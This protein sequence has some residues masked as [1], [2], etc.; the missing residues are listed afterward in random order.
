MCGA[1]RPLGDLQVS[2]PETTIAPNSESNRVTR[3]I[4]RTFIHA[5]LEIR[6]SRQ[7]ELLVVSGRSGRPQGCDPLGREGYV[8]R[9]LR[10]PVLRSTTH[11]VSLPP[12]PGNDA[13]TTL[14]SC[15][16]RGTATVDGP[17]PTGVKGHVVVRNGL[18]ALRADLP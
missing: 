14:E 9:C 4:E 6:M 17:A 2:P 3:G 13:L 16:S 8:H 15:L 1:P 7:A 12:Y 18:A 5:D 10:A 11:G